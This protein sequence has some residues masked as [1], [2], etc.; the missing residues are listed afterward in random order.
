MGADSTL[1]FYGVRQ[2]IPVDGNDDTVDDR[3]YVYETNTHPTQVNAKRLGLDADL[4]SDENDELYLYIGRRIAILSA[5]RLD[6]LYYGYLELNEAKLALI[7]AEV[8]AGLAQLDIADT[9][10]LHF[11]WRPQYH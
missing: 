3:L 2:L 5:E 1:V 9:P 11:D 4:W 7:S 10:A 8:K 6:H